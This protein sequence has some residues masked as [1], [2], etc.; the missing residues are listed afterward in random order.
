MLDTWEG[1]WALGKKIGIGGGLVNSIS[2]MSPLGKTS[3][4]RMLWVAQSTTLVFHTLC[5]VKESIWWVMAS[6][7]A[8]RGS[9]TSSPESFIPYFMT[10]S[11][12]PE[13]SR[14]CSSAFASIWPEVVLA[15]LARMGCPVGT[16][17]DRQ[18]LNLRPNAAMSVP[19]CPMILKVQGDVATS[20][21]EG[22][23]F[24]LL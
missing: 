8:S 22:K 17:S 10:M 20:S 9:N 14:V 12:Q 21:P 3:S 6:L 18:V 15:A 5:R 11:L 1:G 19:S 16:Q 23:S 24:T 13:S 7:A 2:C 4:A